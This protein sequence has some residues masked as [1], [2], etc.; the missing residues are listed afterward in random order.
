MCQ[1]EKDFDYR[2]ELIHQ[3]PLLTQP[4]LSAVNSCPINFSKSFFL[5][6]S[7]PGVSLYILTN[8]DV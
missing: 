2:I 8:D 1:R 7:N 6:L 5:Y 3:L 4:N